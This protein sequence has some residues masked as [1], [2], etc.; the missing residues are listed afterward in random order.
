M[1]LSGQC[2]ISSYVDISSGLGASYCLDAA[3]G[4]LRWHTPALPFNH[5][6][7]AG[8][9]K[10]LLTAYGYGASLTQ[11]RDGHGQILREW[12]RTGLACVRPSGEIVI[13]EEFSPTPSVWELYSDG[14]VRQGAGVSGTYSTPPVLTQ[15]G[16]FIFW[17]AGSLC[18]I[19]SQLQ[20][21]VLH[22]APQLSD[23]AGGSTM[24]LCPDGTFVFGIYDT[25]GR[26]DELWFV[27]SAYALEDKSSWPCADGNMAA[28]P[29]WPLEFGAA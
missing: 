11:L 24:L 10:F 28:N 21:H 3:T 4:Q 7:I 22:S 23:W 13:A 1:L 16:S 25:Q 12:E 26:C 17:R 2:L 6:A 14:S 9:E 15:D 18:E 29:C 5:R 20:L 19:D 27:A 8:Y